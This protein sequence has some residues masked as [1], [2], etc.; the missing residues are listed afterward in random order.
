MMSGKKGQKKKKLQGV[1][2]DDDAH[3]RI[4]K[5]CDSSSYSFYKCPISLLDKMKKENEYVHHVS[6][7]SWIDWNPGNWNWFKEGLLTNE[8]TPETHSISFLFL[9]LNPLHKWFV[10]R[11]TRQ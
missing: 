11:Q 6:V 2:K 4:L 8:R 3:P 10:L 7:L 5:E 9:S 1:A